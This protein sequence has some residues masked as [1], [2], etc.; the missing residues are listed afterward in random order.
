VEFQEYSR[1]SKTLSQVRVEE[2][3][4]L[5]LDVYQA[6][7]NTELLGGEGVPFF[8]IVSCSTTEKN[9]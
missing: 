8:G 9:I 6:M 7:L 2:L 4:T 3:K 5:P 1:S